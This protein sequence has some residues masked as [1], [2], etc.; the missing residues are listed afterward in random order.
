[1][2]LINLFPLTVIKDKLKINS[3]EK[4]LMVNEIRSMKKSS[5]NQKTDPGREESHV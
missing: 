1:M 5:K 3:E 4:N 2:N